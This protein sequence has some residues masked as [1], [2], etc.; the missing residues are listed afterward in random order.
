LVACA[1]RL[2]REGNNG[3]F[4]K[5]SDIVDVGG[6][7]GD[8][9]AALAQNLAPDVEIVIAVSPV[10]YIDIHL[11]NVG[12]AHRGHLHSPLDVSPGKTRLLLEGRRRVVVLVVSADLSADK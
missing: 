7:D 10:S 8:R 11:G 2:S 4:R 3:D 5:P 6:D 1:V 12:Q 9:W